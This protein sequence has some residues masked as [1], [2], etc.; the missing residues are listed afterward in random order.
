MQKSLSILYLL[1]MSGTALASSAE[2]PEPN[3]ENLGW[4]LI[5]TLVVL[6]IVI[7]SIYIT[8]NFGLR[9]LMRIPP[10]SARTAWIKVLDRVPLDAKRILY[11]VKASNDYLLVGGGETQLTLIAK[12]DQSE[13]ERFELSQPHPLPSS[14]SPFLQKLLSRRKGPPPSSSGL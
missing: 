9:R 1:V 7:A 2:V 10:P 5:R 11:V 3:T 6:G 12:L 13:A 4:T 8:L 14:L